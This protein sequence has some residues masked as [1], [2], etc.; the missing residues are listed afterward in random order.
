MSTIDPTLLIVYALAVWRL[1]S[2][3][4]DEMGPLGVFDLIRRLANKLRLGGAF[5]CVW[6][7]SVWVAALVVLAH[8]LAPAAAF[9][10]A[11]VLA[12]SAGAV[13][14]QEVVSWLVQPQR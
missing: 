9:Y 8:V 13:V 4:V 6:C 7:M 1:S 3:L 2:L 12:L 10:G 14:I 11:L 5:S